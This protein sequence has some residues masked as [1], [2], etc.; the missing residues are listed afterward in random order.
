MYGP[1]QIPQKGSGMVA[2]TVYAARNNQ[3]I[4]I[5]GDGKRKRS[6]IF[7]DDVVDISILSSIEKSSENKLFNAGTS[8]ILTTN[9]IIDFVSNLTGKKTIVE[10]LQE[11]LNQAVSIYPDI[12]KMKNLLDYECKTKFSDGLKK[13]IEWQTQKTIL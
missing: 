1:G 5:I 3:P 7:S 12:T 6:Y 11:S 2:D 8:E 13:T 10:H 4:K 9:E